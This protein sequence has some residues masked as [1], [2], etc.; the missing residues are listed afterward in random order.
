MERK[1]L[2]KSHKAL[3]RNPKN[4]NK[5]QRPEI[6]TKTI[7]FYKTT[8]ISE[9]A[10]KDSIDNIKLNPPSNKNVLEASELFFH[11]ANYFLPRDQTG[12]SPDI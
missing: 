10:G 6:Q 7:L 12:E 11:R 8:F 3:K 9:K 5:K 2:L 4:K 1:L